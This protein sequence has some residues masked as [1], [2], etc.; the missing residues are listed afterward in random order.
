MT[1][2]GGKTSVKC[3][4][5]TRWAAFHITAQF[6]KGNDDDKWELELSI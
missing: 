6:E 3:K 5:R 4:E 1:R 2:E